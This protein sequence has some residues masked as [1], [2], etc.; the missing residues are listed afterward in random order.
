M[1]SVAG[2]GASN[3]DGRDRYKL[4]GRGLTPEEAA[5]RVRWLCA[6]VHAKRSH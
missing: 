4:S 6:C 2:G 3:F 1:T 5:E